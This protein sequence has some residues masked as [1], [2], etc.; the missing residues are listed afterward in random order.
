MQRGI[1][2]CVRRSIG[3]GVRGREG[4]GLRREG[5]GGGGGWYSC[6]AQSH[7]YRPSHAYVQCR[8]GARPGFTDQADTA[9]T[10]VCVERRGG[11][12]AGGRIHLWLALNGVRNNRTSGL[13]IQDTYRYKEVKVY[14]SG[15]STTNASTT[16]R[17]RRRRRS[18]R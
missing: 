11:G 17:S 13:T 5:Q 1:D 3:S 12:G 2:L 6:R 18:I 15:R 8:D 16:K 7:D 10:R 4:G 9:C 14:E